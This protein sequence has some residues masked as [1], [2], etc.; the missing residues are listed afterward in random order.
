M[1]EAGRRK[2][3]ERA[4]KKARREMLVPYEKMTPHDQKL[5]DRG[6]SNLLLALRG[7]HVPS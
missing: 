6:T 1:S 3:M 7:R 2:K 5:W 4:A